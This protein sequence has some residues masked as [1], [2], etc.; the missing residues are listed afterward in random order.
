[1]L[2]D[3]GFGFGGLLGGGE[4]A[5]DRCPTRYGKRETLVGGEEEG[6]F[7]RMWDERRL[8]ELEKARRQREMELQEGEGEEI[9]E[10]REWEG[11]VE[12]RTITPRGGRFKERERARFLD[13][14][15]DIFERPPSQLSGMDTVGPVMRELIEDREGRW[16]ERS[17]EEM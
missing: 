11:G 16:E 15:M 4:V 17:V 7:G 6:E 2:R 13:E 3:P 14:E 1:M 12:E 9:I 5:V 8:K 10:M